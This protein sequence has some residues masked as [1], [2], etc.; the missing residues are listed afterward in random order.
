MTT[1]GCHRVA[2]L[3]VVALLCLAV[4]AAYAQDKA[5]GKSPVRKIDVVQTDDAYVA[6]IEMYAPVPPATAWTVLTDFDKMAGFVPNVH[7]SKIVERSGNVLTVEQKGTAKF[8]LLSIP[9]TSV[10][11]MELDPQKTIKAT[12][13]QGNM[14]RLGSLMKVSPGDNG[15]TRLDYRLEVVP[16]AIASAVMSTD[17]LKGELTDQFTAI[18]GEMVKRTK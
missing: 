13:V 7:E 9:Y 18:V 8:G 3:V 14:K 12:Q 11:K 5:K 1:P 4:G 16:S 10:R 6:T 17:F 15:G 2:P